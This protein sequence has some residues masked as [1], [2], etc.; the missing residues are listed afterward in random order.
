[1]SRAVNYDWKLRQEARRREYLARISNNANRFIAKYR[2]LLND[3]SRQGLDQ[4]ITSEFSQAQRKLAMAESAL[5][6]DPERARDLSVELGLEISGLPAL[7]RATKN[8]VIARE[9]QRQEELALMRERASVE[10][11][12]LLQAALTEISDPIERDYAFDELKQLQTEY[13]G[14]MVQPDEIAQLEVAIRQRLQKIQGA[15]AN[16]AQEWKDRKT[17]EA[18]N[19]TAKTLIDMHRDEAT[20]ERD[21]NPK[22]IE[23]LLTRLDEMRTQLSKPGW[24]IDQV[25]TQLSEITAQTDTAVVDENCRR[26]TV[27]SVLEALGKAGFVT[28]APQRQVG[29]SDEVII[30]ARKPSG[31]EATFRITVDG[32]LSYKFEHYEGNECKN[33]IDKV[34]PLLQEVYGIE[35]SNER[36]LWQNPDRISRSA[37]PI[38]VLGQEKKHGK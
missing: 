28:A 13:A 8:E 11:S 2:S 3:L 35:L 38:D 29:D 12:Q 27:R 23:G 5:S 24:T 22:A 4:Y 10:F 9:R 33:D 31:N 19:E 32:G 20:Q 7:A 1:M 34:L 16:K 14:R 25:K 15:A 17:R 21:R 37:R 30:T 26:T 36:V 18:M 6:G